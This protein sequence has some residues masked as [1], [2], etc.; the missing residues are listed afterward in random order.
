[1]TFSGQSSTCLIDGGWIAAIGR[2]V[3]ART[4]AFALLLGEFGLAPTIAPALKDEDLDVVGESVDEGD[5]A[6]GIGEAGFSDASYGFRPGRSVAPRNA[7]SM[8]PRVAGLSLRKRVAR[9]TAPIPSCSSMPIAAV[10]QTSPLRPMP[11]SVEPQVQRLRGLPGEHAVDGN[12]VPW[13]RHLR[14]DGDLVLAEAAL[15]H[16]GGRLDGRDSP[17]EN[18]PAI[19]PA[20]PPP[21]PTV[22]GAGADCWFTTRE[23][24]LN[25]VQLPQSHGTELYE[26]FRR[27]ASS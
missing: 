3:A 25:H 4:S 5:G 6:R 17:H 27:Q 14:G 26:S 21:A 7:P 16:E 2:V 24:P 22:K 19:L 1:M 8:T 18:S 12:E 13:P 10:D 23:P 9:S 15:A 20:D 11:A